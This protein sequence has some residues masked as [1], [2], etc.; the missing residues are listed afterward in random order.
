MLIVFACVD[1][2]LCTQDVLS[3]FVGHKVS[4]RRP[5]HTHAYICMAKVS[6]SMQRLLCYLKTP[7]DFKRQFHTTTDD[8][9]QI[10]RFWGLTWLNGR[11]DQEVKA[12]N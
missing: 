5:M 11:L 7:L 3:Q 6:M 9:T 8:W 1:L 12:R 2:K 4:I 10:A